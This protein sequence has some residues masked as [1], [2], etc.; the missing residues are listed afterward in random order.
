MTD[1]TTDDNCFLMIQFMETWIVADQE[2][3]KKFCGTGYSESAFPKWSDLENVGKETIMNAL[4]KATKGTKTKSECHKTQHG[5][6]LLKK[7]NTET[8]RDRCPSCDRLFS[9][10]TEKMTTL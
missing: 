1:G 4:K 5:F 7:V 3:L 2:N 6:D 9:T 10:L 8:I